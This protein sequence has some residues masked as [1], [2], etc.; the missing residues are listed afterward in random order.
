MQPKNLLSPACLV[1]KFAGADS[2]AAA[3][4]F[5]AFDGGAAKEE[6]TID[7]PPLEIGVGQTGGRLTG[8]VDLSMLVFKKKHMLTAENNKIKSRSA[9]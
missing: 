9:L 7:A 3:S 4:N 5:E 6:L 1:T 8:G 2:S